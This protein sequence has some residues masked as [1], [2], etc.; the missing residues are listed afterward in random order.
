MR[1]I[2]VRFQEAYDTSGLLQQCMIFH[3]NE[4]HLQMLPALQILQTFAYQKSW[5]ALAR[6]E[7]NL[8]VRVSVVD[9]FI[10]KQYQRRPKQ[11][12]AAQMAHIKSN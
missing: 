5:T 7:W 11:A 10:G 12:A 2:F 1:Q 4:N 8:C 9:A 3:R 6:K